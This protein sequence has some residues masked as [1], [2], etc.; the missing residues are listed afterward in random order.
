[1]GLLVESAGAFLL[2]ALHHQ[3]GFAA[4]CFYFS[5]LWVGYFFTWLIL[6]HDKF[7]S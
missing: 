4:I 2:A 6:N 3:K 7:R 1:M 5:L